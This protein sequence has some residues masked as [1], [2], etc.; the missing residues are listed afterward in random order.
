[1]KICDNAKNSCR[2]EPSP[3]QRAHNKQYRLMSDREC[4]DNRRIC[5]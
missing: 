2:C 4:A 5:G 3:G 1:M